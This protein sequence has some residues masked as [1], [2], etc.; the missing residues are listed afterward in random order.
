MCVQSAC[1]ILAI[2]I[3]VMAME[4][5]FKMQQTYGSSVGVS[6]QEISFGIFWLA[7]TLLAQEIYFHTAPTFGSKGQAE[8]ASTKT[9][10]SSL[11]THIQPVLHWLHWL[12]MKYC[13]KFKI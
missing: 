7:Y 8:C 5:A 2:K 10:G 3:L 6:R 1:K 12:P 9:I 4:S 13:F 11:W